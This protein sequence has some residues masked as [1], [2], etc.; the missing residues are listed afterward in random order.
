MSDPEGERRR[1]EQRE[2]TREREREQAQVEAEEGEGQL[3]STSLAILILPVIG[4]IGLAIWIFAL[5]QWLET[6]FTPGVRIGFIAG[7]S[8]MWAM[9]AGG[10]LLY[11]A[12]TATGKWDFENPLNPYD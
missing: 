6:F 8:V 2:W 1:G 9:A 4:L 5:T 7:F 12:L 10:V 11:A 3:T